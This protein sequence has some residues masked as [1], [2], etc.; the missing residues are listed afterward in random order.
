MRLHL[1]CSMGAAGDMLTA[2][3]LDLLP[4]KRAFLDKM[5]SLGIPGVV[6]ESVRAEK[7]GVSGLRV[8]VYIDGKTEFSEDFDPAEDCDRHLHTHGHGPEHHD[9][10]GGGHSHAH[11][12]YS[13]SGICRLISSLDLPEKVRNDALAVYRL[14]GEAEAEVHGREIEQ[15]HFHEVG[16]LDA[17][18]DVVGFCLLVHMLAPD[19]IT[20]SPVHV[21]S[22]FVRCSHGI[23][24]VP[25]PATALLLRGIPI[26]GGKIKGELCTPTGAALLRHFVGGFGEM[27]AMSVR[28]IGYGMGTKDF[29]IANCVRAFWGEC[30]EETGD[31]AEIVCN[32][33]DMTPE[34]IGAVTELLLR[35]GALDVYTA[36]VYMKKNRPA[37]LLGCLCRPEDRN[38]LS[39][40]ILLH[41]STFGVRFSLLNR[42]VLD[43]GFYT[44]ETEY[45]TIR[46]KS[47][48][49]W[50]IVKEKPEYEDVLSASRAHDATFSEVYRS[51][52]AAI[53]NLRKK[54]AG[55]QEID[56][57]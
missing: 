50:G 6:V 14:I 44:V 54:G 18:A 34:A 39:R 52:V 2:A 15:I 13:Y 46:V 8:N 36:P 41:T 3:L 22:G 47:G 24:P 26:Y 19:S 33:D 7:C 42:R 32:L 35:S 27:S 29:E 45:G 11:G 49:G 43:V 40:L 53:E 48:S 51:A 30:G 55:H 56:T 38:E 37:T 57:F 20:A 16:S 21:G 23:L 4:E 25:A 9:S 31:V 17:V 1:E 5:N 10:V 28:R 12:H